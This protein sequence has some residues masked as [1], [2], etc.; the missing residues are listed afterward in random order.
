PP[1]CG[2]PPGSFVS[3]SVS[4]VSSVASVSSASASWEASSSAPPPQAASINKVNSNANNATECLR[5]ITKKSSS[6][7]VC[8]ENEIS[9]VSL[10]ITP[11]NVSLSAPLHA[12]CFLCMQVTCDIVLRLYLDQIWPFA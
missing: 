12:L 4:S 6:F 5:L 11:S 7:K 10:S 9:N 1:A 3:A 8:L 2:A